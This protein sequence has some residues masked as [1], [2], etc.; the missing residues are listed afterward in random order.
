MFT[1]VHGIV[2]IAVF[3]RALGD[4]GRGMFLVGEDANLLS[5]LD[6]CSVELRPRTTRERDNPHI[7]IGHHQPV[8]QH[9]QGIERGVEHNLSLGHLA[10]D[11]IGEAEEEGVAAGKDYY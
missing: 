10:P 2:A 1:Y 6:E 5:S 7:V 11:G 4:G 9:L 8:G 3:K